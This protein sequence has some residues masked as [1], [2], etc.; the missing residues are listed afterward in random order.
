VFEKKMII[1]YNVLNN[2][3]PTHEEVVNDFNENVGETGVLVSNV[4]AERV[5]P[6]L[7]LCSA[8]KVGFGSYYS[9][10]R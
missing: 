6:I 5:Q 7:N 2:K 10:N 9:Y 1:Y 8:R 3:K 4:L